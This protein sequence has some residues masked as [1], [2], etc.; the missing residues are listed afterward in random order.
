MKIIIS[1]QQYKLIKEQVSPVKIGCR[2][3]NKIGELCNTLVF[4]KSE[5]D[6]LISKY[7]PNAD[8]KL[9]KDIDDVADYVNIEYYPSHEYENLIRKKLAESITISK[10]LILKV[11]SNYYSKAIYY[12][13]GLGPEIILSPIISEV[14]GIIYSQFIKLLNKNLVKSKIS[15]KNI[16]EVKERAEQIFEDMFQLELRIEFYFYSAYDKVKER[17]IEMEKTTPKCSKVIITHDRACNPIPQDSP[18]QTYKNIE[19]HTLTRDEDDTFGD[20]ARQIYIPKLLSFL[21]NLV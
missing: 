11:L 2:D 8:E 6:N 3:Y 21:N 1:E 12:S 9:L 19:N 10:R 5:A 17:V 14:W 18:R 20:A 15:S 7:K 4:P 16:E 13:C